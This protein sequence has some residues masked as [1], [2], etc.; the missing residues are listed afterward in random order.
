MAYASDLRP[1][2][3]TRRQVQ[4]PLY[5]GSST[6]DLGAELEEAV[7]AK[8]DEGQEKR[9]P[10]QRLQ[11]HEEHEARHAY[12]SA[13]TAHG[14]EEGDDRGRNNQPVPNDSAKQRV[15]ILLHR[16]VPCHKSL[17]HVVRA[18]KM[19]GE[20]HHGTLPP[21]CIASEQILSKTMCGVARGESECRPY[22]RASR[23]G[24]K[25]ST[26][27]F[28]NIR[29]EDAPVMWSKIRYKNRNRSLSEPRSRSNCISATPSQPRLQNWSLRS[30]YCF[31]VPKAE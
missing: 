22:Q 27:R 26:A 10:E 6:R 24:S 2:R 9:H 12:G 7:E 17:T 15:V 1:P 5:G 13:G 28:A 3:H 16:P 25:P 11:V 4:L 21:R 14:G 30:F 19:N 20:T 31:C 18:D 29:R 23:E 8:V